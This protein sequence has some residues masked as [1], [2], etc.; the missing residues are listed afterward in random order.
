MVADVLKL[1]MVFSVNL[2]GRLWLENLS[3]VLGWKRILM[4]Q[5]GQRYGIEDF[6]PD[7]E[8]LYFRLKLLSGSF[9]PLL[10]L[11]RNFLPFLLCLRSSPSFLMPT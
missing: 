9:L 4:A 1:A 7:L 11:P 5:Q 10:F 2:D 8:C 3:H 6:V